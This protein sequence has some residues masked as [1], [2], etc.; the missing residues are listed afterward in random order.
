V[1]GLLL[2]AAGVI[3]FEVIELDAFSAFELRYH[4]RSQRAE[5]R[6]GQGSE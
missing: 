6:E 4:S 1:A 3:G 5:A 2:A